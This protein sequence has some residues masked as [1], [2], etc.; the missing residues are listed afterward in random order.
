M[1]DQT[2]KKLFS[3]SIIATERCNVRCTYCHF[4]SHVSRSSRRDISDRM[5]TKYLDFIRAIGERNPTSVVT[6]RFSGGDPT[7]LGKRLFELAD[8][9]FSVTGVEPYILTAGKCLTDAY[10]AEARKHHISALVVSLENPLNPD[11]GA[12]DPMWVMKRVR[13]LSTGD[14][15]I[16]LGSTIVQNEDFGDVAEICDIVFD[17]TGQLP[18]LQEKNFF[19]YESP[20]E[21]QLQDLHENLVAAIRKYHRLAP[22]NFFPY[23]SPEFSASHGNLPT[24]LMELDIDNRYQIGSRSQSTSEQQLERIVAHNYPALD[25]SNPKCQWRSGCRQVKWVWKAGSDLVDPAQKLTDY[26]RFKRCINGAF[27]RAVEATA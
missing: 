13:A 12:L 8:E 26:C 27:Y 20:T 23:V 14:L 21:S 4:Y 5:Y 6:F 24:Y 7:V 22:L 2:G 16:R 1:Q 25:C 11:P 15:P 18:K 10:V 9:G 19:A 17:C 3:F